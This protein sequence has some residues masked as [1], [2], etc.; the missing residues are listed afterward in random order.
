MICSIV[1]FIMSWSD[2]SVP[3]ILK[4]HVDSCS[5][6]SSYQSFLKGLPNGFK[7]ALNTEES[8]IRVKKPSLE[9]VK[10]NIEIMPRR[11]RKYGGWITGAAAAGVAGLMILSGTG[12]VEKSGGIDLD[13]LLSILPSGE[14]IGSAA[15]DLESPIE[16]EIAELKKAFDSSASF[17]KDGLTIKKSSPEEG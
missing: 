5:K 17:L 9:S 13:K 3:G 8:K 10:G 2:G 12:S 4:K 7:A 11:R 15:A 1:K 6:C 16:M 14:T